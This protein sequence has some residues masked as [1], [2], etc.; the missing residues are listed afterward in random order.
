MEILRTI[1]ACSKARG[2][3][4]LLSGGHAVNAYGIP[5]QTG[6]VELIVP[7]EKKEAWLELLSNLKYSEHRSTASFSRLRPADLAA[8]PIDLIYVDQATF[9]KLFNAAREVEIGRAKVH[10]VSVTHLVALKIHALQTAA[11][12][13]QPKDYRDVMGLLKAGQV[14]LSDNELKALCARYGDSCLFEKL[15]SDLRGEQ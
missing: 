13:R 8:W 7:A 11:P 14:K 15:M 5:R 12:E 6:L 9:A 3:E 1:S 4:F 2:L 10:A